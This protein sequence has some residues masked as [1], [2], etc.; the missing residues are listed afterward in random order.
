MLLFTPNVTAAELE[1]L[2]QDCNTKNMKEAIANSPKIGDRITKKIFDTFIELIGV[3]IMESPEKEFYVPNFETF[4]VKIHRG[5]KVKLNPR[6]DDGEVVNLLDYK[7]L[8][9]KPD[10][11]FK[12]DVFYTEKNK[13]FFGIAS[14]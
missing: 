8:R 14:P 1:N 9:F 3:K 4:A 5:H 13:A 10:D 11:K 6:E 7:M 2:P 12:S